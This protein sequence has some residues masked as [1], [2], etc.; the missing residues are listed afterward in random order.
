[1]LLPR[2]VIL[3]DVV[4]MIGK[5]VSDGQGAVSLPSRVSRK[6]ICVE[7]LS[8]ICVG[9][10][11]GREQKKKIARYVRRQTE[12][13]TEFCVSCVRENVIGVLVF[14]R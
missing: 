14:V 11:V 9:R 10:D 5:G 1:M 7:R 4:A 13:Q 12:R 8:K 6:H 2:R 3:R